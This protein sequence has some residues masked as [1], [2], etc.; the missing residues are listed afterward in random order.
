MLHQPELS[1]FKDFLV[2]SAGPRAVNIVAFEGTRV[3]RVLTSTYKQSE[4]SNDLQSF[5]FVGA[6]VASIVGLGFTWKA[7]RNLAYPR[8]LI[9]ANAAQLR[10]EDSGAAETEGAREPGFHEGG[11]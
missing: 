10:G 2:R 4:R 7:R 1:F 11:P 9:L 8:R 5:I 3:S 6:I